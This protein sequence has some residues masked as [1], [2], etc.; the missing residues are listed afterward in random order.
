MN[1]RQSFSPIRAWRDLR[2]YL[3]TRRPHQLGFMALSL[4]LTYT[5]ILGTLD[6]SRMPKPAYHRD[7]IYVQ[8][9]RA[10]R[11]IAEIVAQQKIDGVEQTRREKELK[12]LQDER[13]AQLKKLDDTLKSYGI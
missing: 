12:R 5:M 9:W 8:Q 11:T 7:I 6:V 3:V 2:T 1:L 13:K 4:V 10:D